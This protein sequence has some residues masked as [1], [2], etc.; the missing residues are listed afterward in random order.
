GVEI[1]FNAPI[2]ALVERDGRVTGA[3]I[4]AADGTLDVTAREGVVLAT[5]GYGHNQ[6]YRDAFMPHPVPVNSMASEFNTGDGI[7]LSEARGARIAPDEH[8]RSGLW[9]PVSVTM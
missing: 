3:T 6:K 2:A 9:T 5:G 8:R 7:A 4:N 1:L